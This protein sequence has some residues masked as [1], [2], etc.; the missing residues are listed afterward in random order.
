MF[1]APRYVPIRRLQMSSK[2]S[3]VNIGT[4]LEATPRLGPIDR[5]ILATPR[6]RD[7][8]LDRAL[9]RLK[10]LIRRHSR[11][12]TAL[13][14]DLC[15]RRE[16]HRDAHPSKKR[17]MAPRRAAAAADQRVRG[18]VVF[19]RGH[20][21]RLRGA[22]E[23]LGEEGR[24]VALVA[25]S[26]YRVVE[27][28]GHQGALRERQKLVVHRHEEDQVTGITAKSSA[29]PGGFGRRT[30]A[31]PRYVQWPLYAGSCHWQEWVPADGNNPLLISAH[32][33]GP[34]VCRTSG[35]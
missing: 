35:H 11:L 13:E 30:A 32:Q 9:D 28:D 21:L 3:I 18:G 15:S 6:A 34:Q 10:L 23:N 24:R 22:K 26:K 27:A 19:E 25:C 1:K 5:P 4:S 29:A 33:L 7:Q 31:R 17:L 20:R 12:R 2:S 8:V 16:R 14:V